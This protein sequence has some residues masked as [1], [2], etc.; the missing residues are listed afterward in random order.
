MK[1]V[2]KKHENT[3]LVLAGFDHCHGE[4]QQYAEQIGEGQFVKYLGWR[5]DVGNLYAMADICVASSILEGLGLNLVEAMYSGLPVVATKNRGHST[6]IEDGEN[7]FLVEQG[8]VE[9]FAEKVNSL[10]EN[11]NLRIKFIEAGYCTQEKYRDTNVLK[12]IRNILE[13]I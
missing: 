9:Q 13:N 7:G 3:Y 2:R 5:E 12:K 4:Y 10:I 1:L 6:V 11:E 8:N